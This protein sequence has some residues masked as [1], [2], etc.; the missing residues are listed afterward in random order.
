[1]PLYIKNI[2]LFIMINMTPE[3]KNFGSKGYMRQAQKNTSNWRFTS[4][5]HTQS[6]LPI[7]CVL[8]TWQ[9][10]H[11]DINVVDKTEIY[12]QFFFNRDLSL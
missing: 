4:W 2:L 11:L 7:A 6:V 3:C 1:M 9:K 10:T 12:I 5:F 8:K